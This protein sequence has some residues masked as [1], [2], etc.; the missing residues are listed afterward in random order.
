MEK[1]NIKI[2]SVII[3]I[4]AIITGIMNMSVYA[5]ENYGYDEAVEFFAQM[6]VINKENIKDEAINRGEFVELLM[7][8]M[9]NPYDY[10][11]SE[12]TFNDVTAE[13]TWFESVGKAYNQGIINGYTKNEFRPYEKISVSQAITVMRNVLNVVDGVREA[14][15]FEI[16]TQVSDVDEI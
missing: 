12:H 2:L 14:K 15:P 11:S 7:K 1:T 3:C 16:V 6:G 8:A 13:Q 9:N 5:E 4:A 10:I